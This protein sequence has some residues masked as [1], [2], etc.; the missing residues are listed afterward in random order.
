MI[1]VYARAA[2]VMVIVGCAVGLA[3][4]AVAPILPYEGEI[5]FASPFGNL[6]GIDIF[7]L[8]VIHRYTVNLTGNSDFTTFATQHEPICWLDR[9]RLIALTTQFSND[10]L[11]PPHRRRLLTIIDLL[12]GTQTQIEVDVYSIVDAQCNPY[13]DTILLKANSE[14]LD[15]TMFYMAHP[16]SDI[17]DV[18]PLFDRCCAYEDAYSLS[19][20]GKSVLLAQYMAIG[21]YYGLY[22]V[23][24][25]TQERQLL[26]IHPNSI[27]AV[28]WV[29]NSTK[30]I[31]YS[32][33]NIWLLDTNTRQTDIIS[34]E[35]TSHIYWSADG[36]N[37]ILVWYRPTNNVLSDTLIDFKDEN[38][39]LQ[40]HSVL[41]NF[42]CNSF[43]WSPNGQR[44]VM[45][46][47][48]T[49]APDLYILDTNS[50]LF[51]R[52]N[53]FMFPHRNI[54]WRPE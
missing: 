46:C 5:A 53:T 26:H 51:V 31:F 21:N 9:N 16:D 6:G 41:I 11:E 27:N 10:P 52:L 15:N 49:T 43:H 25:E 2:V 34:S 36:L 19:H 47:Y 40:R 17:I 39:Q 37:S 33:S 29:P 1:R 50:Q 32:N 4:V 23:N 18:T 38:N 14:Y 24:L 7:L 20:N 3:A 44:I 54:M 30:I 28:Y 22:V 48:S 12:R 45:S 42:E 8:D 13:S 35:Y